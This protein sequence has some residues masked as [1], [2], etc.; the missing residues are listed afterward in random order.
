MPACCTSDLDNPCSAHV[1][2]IENV[3]MSVFQGGCV[4]IRYDTDDFEVILEEDKT[5][6]LKEHY[7]II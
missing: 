5:I 2:Q 4:L 6:G 7:N 1:L 3:V